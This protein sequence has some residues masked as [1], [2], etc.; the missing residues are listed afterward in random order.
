MDNDIYHLGAWFRQV[1]KD[2]GY[3]LTQVAG[4]NFSPAALSR[5]ERGETDIRGDHLTAIML[6]LASSVQILPTINV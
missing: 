3:T 2:R 5:F 4:K 6:N 1:R